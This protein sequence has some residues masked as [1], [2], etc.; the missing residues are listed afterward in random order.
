MITSPDYASTSR[1]C[2]FCAESIKP[3]AKV[4][5]RCRQWLTLRSI[6]NP[7]IAVWVF[8]IPH[9]A[10]YGLLAV[11]LLTA[12]D[13]MQNPRPDYTAFVNS[14]R[15]VGSWMNWAETTNGLRIYITGILTNQSPVAWRDIELQCRF[16][17]AHGGLVD[18]VHPRLFLTIQPHD[19]TAFRTIVTPSRATN[20]YASFKL[21]VTTARN[22][23]SF[24]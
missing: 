5:P 12:L 13:R 4:C 10:L 18:A 6:R 8:S 17:D 16:L 19:D 9:L 23:K 20:D 3:E 2:P 24:F 21:T 15:V 11:L 1:A 14:V 7:A 22:T